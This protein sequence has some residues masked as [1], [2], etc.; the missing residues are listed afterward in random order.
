MRSRVHKIARIA[1]FV[2]TLIGAAFGAVV[3]VA[4]SMWGG[5]FV[6][7]PV[8]TIIFGLFG[9][10]LGGAAEFLI[11]MRCPVDYEL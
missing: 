1:T 2:L 7:V 10:L 8:T 3:G 11:R 9:A 5:L 4:A 6:I